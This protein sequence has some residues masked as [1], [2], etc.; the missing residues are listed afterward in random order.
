MKVYKKVKG[1]RS[2]SAGLQKTVR[3]PQKMMGIM[4]KFRDIQK[5]I[6]KLQEVETVAD[7]L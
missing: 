2:K 5:A 6:C 3:R 4:S 7:N 1:M